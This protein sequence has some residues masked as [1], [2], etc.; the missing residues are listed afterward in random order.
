MSIGL[1]DPVLSQT[2]IIPPPPEQGAL[3]RVILFF[4]TS[5]RFRP[6][7]FSPT[8]S[9]L[10]SLLFAQSSACIMPSM[11][12]QELSSRILLNPMCNL[13]NALCKCAVCQHV[14]CTVH[15]ALNTVCVIMYK[16]CNVYT[17]L[18]S[19]GEICKM[20][21]WVHC[22]GEQDGGA[23]QWKKCDK[24]PKSSLPTLP[25]VH[26]CQCKYT[27]QELWGWK[28]ILMRSKYE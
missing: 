6:T 21:W 14:H 12:W 28:G 8:L 24:P 26:I 2:Y 9:P 25:S 23:V 27:H 1:A 19:S 17:A 5:S 16:M 20:R 3:S 13:L 22:K 11:K 18:P 7:P 10:Y 4:L 15:R